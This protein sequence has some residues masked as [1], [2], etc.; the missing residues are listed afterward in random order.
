MLDT[1][2]IA[3]IVLVALASAYLIVAIIGVRLFRSKL[4]LPTQD[5]DWGP[6]TVLKPLCGMEVEL[7]E[8]LRSFCEQDYQTF[9][10]IFGVRDADDPAIDV[11][12][13]IIEEYPKLDIS[14]VINDR[15]IGSNP[16]VGNLANMYETARHD[17]IVIADSDMRVGR[18]YLKAVAQVF[19]NKD[20]GAA[21]CLYSGS[22][23]GGLSSRLGA[24]F[25]N[26]WFFPSALIPT[27]FGELKFCFGATMA[28]RRDALQEI[29]SF[30]ALANVLADDYMLGNL[31]AKLGYRIA[32]VPY[33]VENIVHEP[34][35]KALFLHEVRWAR[36]IRSVQPGGYAMSTM[37]ETLPLAIIASILLYMSTFSTLLIASP[38]L[39]VLGLRLVLHGSVSGMIRGERTFSPWLIPVRDMFSFAVRICSFFGSKV[40]WRK[41]VMTVR[42]NSRLQ[43]AR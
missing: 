2:A 6:L 35:L 40:H 17:L 11:A 9:Q 16:K 4:N 20:V 41:Q 26:D 24:M 15:V 30:E 29:G 18:D 8:N 28:V 39:C 21:T 10:I 22:A 32:L 37:T 31:V 5:E 19:E 38:V 43:N 1:Y 13:G 42:S 34:G 23:R 36:T 25:I 3:A 12:K 7:A 27:L 33:I 14:L